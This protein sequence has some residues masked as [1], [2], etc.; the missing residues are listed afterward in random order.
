MDS[1]LLGEMA[2]DVLPGRFAAV[3]AD[4]SSIS[5]VEKEE[6]LAFAAQQ[7]FPVRVSRAREW[8]WEYRAHGRVDVSNG[9]PS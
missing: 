5:L 8:S 3:L 4:S 1:P 2:Q 7:G 6:A 9:C